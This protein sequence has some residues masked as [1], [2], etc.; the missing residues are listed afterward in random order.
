MAGIGVV[1]PTLAQVGAQAPH[2]ASGVGEHALGHGVELAELQEVVEFA[3]PALG[4][5]DLAPEIGHLGGV[6][7]DMEQLTTTDI[8]VVLGVEVFVFGHGHLR[9]GRRGTKL[10]GLPRERGPNDGTER[11][12][13]WGKGV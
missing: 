1:A 7:G 4:L 2:G 12:P 13:E 6:A 3:A 8:V 9:N 10:H 11:L 5:F